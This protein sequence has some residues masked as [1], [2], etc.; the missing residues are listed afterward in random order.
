[1]TINLAARFLLSAAALPVLLY[2]IPAVARPDDGNGKSDVKFTI[3]ASARARIEAIDGQFRPAT[4][5][6]DVFVSFRT[7]VAARLDMGDFALGGEIV[8]ARG[9]AESDKSSVKTTEIDALEPVQAYAAYRLRDVAQKGDTLTATLG[10]FSLDIGSSRLV[11]RTDFPNTVLSYLGAMGEWRTK[12]KD[13]FVLF[14]T[15]P[16]T[17]L[18][19]DAG[20]IHHNGFKFDRAAGN[21]TFFGTSGTV[22]EAFKNVSLE[23]YGYRLVEEDRPGRLTRDRHLSTFGTRIRRAPAKGKFDF[24]AEG[25]LQR[26]TARA[27]TAANDIKD[28]EVQAS[29]GHAEAGWTAAKGWM[30]R[31]SAMFDYAS[32]DGAKSSYGRFDTLFGARRADF[33]PVALYGPIGRANLISPGARIEAKPSKRFDLMAAVRGLWLADATDAFASTGVRDK[34]GASGR[35]AGTQI[36]ARARRWLIPDRLR[37][38]AGAAYLAKGH[39]LRDAPNAPKTGDTRYGYM[40][41]AVS[42]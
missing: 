9:Y 38:E 21:M 19:D 12:G 20:A 4:S 25:A 31:I 33:G 36:E 41:L 23:I 28:L 30:P 15:E 29:F 10:R 37:L 3:D 5:P 32:A 16:F 17:A 14:W 8:D 39:F 42:F 1:V 7:T 2:A 40:D 24:E 27:T 11:G 6:D 34:T 22:A 18:P 35:H 26:G 13:R